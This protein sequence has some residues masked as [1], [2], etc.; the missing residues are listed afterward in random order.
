[1]IYYWLLF[2]LSILLISLAKGVKERKLSLFVVVILFFTFFA[3]RIGFT[4]DYYNY[5]GL[6][7]KFHDTLFLDSDDR[8]EIGFQWI[9]I[10]LPSYRGLLITYTAFFCICLYITLRYF[11]EKRF[12]VLAIS[13]LFCYTPFVLGN[14]SGLRSG[15]VTCFFFIALFIRAR[16]K[17]RGII[18]S[19]SIMIISYTFHKS[20]IV[21]FPL[22]LLPMQPLGNLT[23]KVMY[24]LAAAFIVM[25]LFFGEKLNQFA[26]TMSDQIFANQYD[27]YFDEK[28]V[29]QFS[30]FSLI[31]KGVEATLLYITIGCAQKEKNMTANLF[32]KITAVFYLFVIAPGIGLTA[33]FYYYFAFPCIIGTSYLIGSLDKMTRKVYLLCFFFLIL[34]QLYFFYKSPAIVFFMEYE[35]LL[36]L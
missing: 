12:W 5:E 4:P 23:K 15:F 17:M 28:F 35:N 24:I 27:T 13:I 25:S 9:C 34:W 31:A 7:N 20:S 21:L 1:M 2:F 26:L 32:V 29:N 11:V 30:F 22:L 18:V 19:L 33:R 14:M 16:Y 36:F 6:F 3:F 8:F 10:I